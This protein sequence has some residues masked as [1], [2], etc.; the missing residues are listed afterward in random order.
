MRGEDGY[1]LRSLPTLGLCSSE[2]WYSTELP[3]YLTDSLVSM[4]SS[5]GEEL[6]RGVAPFATD[7]LWMRINKML[8]L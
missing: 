5:P 7:G 2:L 3:C 4:L 1:P 8:V 6:G